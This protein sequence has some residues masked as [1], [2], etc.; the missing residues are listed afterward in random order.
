MVSSEFIINKQE[1]YTEVAQ[2][3]SYTGAKMDD[4]ATAFDRISTTDEDQSQLER[5]WNETCVSVSEV[6]RRFLSDEGDAYTVSGDTKTY[7]GY[8]FTFEFSSSFDTKL[9][10]SMQKEL[11]SFFVMNITAKWYGFT[12]KKES[13]EYATA[14]A[15][16]LEGFHRKAC[17]KKKPQRPSYTT[18]TTTGAEQTTNNN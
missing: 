15:G 10:P 1:V 14:A 6:M 2:T 17:F 5:F 18:A 12:N 7:V 8:S 9:L 4:D 13:S 16:L 3:S 11:F